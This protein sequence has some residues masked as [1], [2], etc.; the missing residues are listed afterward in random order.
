MTLSAGK[1]ALSAAT[2][3]AFAATG[4]AAQE[5]TA[6]F[7][8]AY[9]I[10]PGARADFDNGYK[11]H[12]DWHAGKNDKLVWYGWYV[13]SGENVGMFIDGTFGASLADIDARPNLPGDGADFAAT[14]APHADAAWYAA[15]RYLPEASTA[16]TLERREPS[17]VLDA[18]RVDI[19]P[20]AMAAFESA[21][22]K[23]AANDRGS[24]VAWYRPALGGDLSTYLALAPRKTW[25]DLDGYDSLRGL[26]LRSGGGDGKTVDNA[27]KLVASVKSEIWSYRADLSYF[28]PE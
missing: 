13:S 11:K 8:Y 24:G 7:L 10:K 17:A 27:L 20:G 3:F 12:L 15:Y 5:K 9:T 19:A 25:E 21:L 22:A 4:A 14:A 16:D 28:P 26:F 2:A 1:L 6:A 23:L 18:Y